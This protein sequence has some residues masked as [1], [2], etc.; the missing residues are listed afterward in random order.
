MIRINRDFRQ[1]HLEAWWLAMKQ[2]EGSDGPVYA[3][4]VVRAAIES[5]IA[6]SDEDPGDMTAKDVIQAAKEINQM[7][8]EAVTISPS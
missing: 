7:I 4:K 5:G 3:G 8:T 1:K 6:T 2:T